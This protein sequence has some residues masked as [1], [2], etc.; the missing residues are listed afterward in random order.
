[1]LN[2]FVGV[3]GKNGLNLEGSKSVGL[4]FL[5]K[6]MTE[7]AVSDYEPGIYFWIAKSSSE[8]VPFEEVNYGNLTSR[9]NSR[10]QLLC[11]LI[12]M[13]TPNQSITVDIMS[14]SENVG[15]LIVLKY[16]QSPTIN[17]TNQLYDSFLIS[18]PNGELDTKL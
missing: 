7:S 18:C 9:V 12:T 16:G 10:N 13:S 15:Y 5:T 1:M 8:D 17:S 3:N 11:F 14:N 4:K 6:N 2:A